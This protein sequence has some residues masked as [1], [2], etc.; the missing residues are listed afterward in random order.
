M[1]PWQVACPDPTAVAT[2]AFTTNTPD[3]AVTIAGNNASAFAAVNTDDYVSHHS[4]L[5][6]ADA[7]VNPAAAAAVNPAV[8]AV[9]VHANPAISAPG[10]NSQ[11]MYK[12]NASSVTTVPRGVQFALV[13]TQLYFADND[14]KVSTK[15]NPKEII[16]Q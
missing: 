9:I 2:P 7:V 16:N 4:A 11:S 5:F 12:D 3:Q 15:L 1:V 10:K 13:V 8:A 6:T 14:S